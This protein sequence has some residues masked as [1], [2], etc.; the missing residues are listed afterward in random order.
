[1]KTR[2]QSLL[3]LLGTLLL[4][5]VGVPRGALGA[6]G[7][8]DAAY[9]PNPG[10]YVFCG[11]LQPDGKLVIGG[12]FGNIGATARSRIARLDANGVVDAAFNPGANNY[13]RSLVVQADGKIIVGGAFTT[14]AGGARNMIARLNA[15]GTLDTTFNPNITGAGT[16][17]D[18]VIAMATQPDGKIVVGGVFTAVG[19]VTRNYVARL[20][21]D[22]T[23]DAA[24][25]PNANS[26]VT[27]MSLRSDGKIFIGG[28]FTSVGASSG[29]SLAL[30]N[31]DGTVSSLYGVNSDVWSLAAQA[32]GKIVFG[33]SFSAVGSF[34]RH[35]LARL[36]ADGS[37]DTLFNPDVTLPNYTSTSVDD[38][39]IQTNGAMVI[40]GSFTTVG[41]VTHKSLARLNPD[42]T[43]DAVFNPILGNDI[44]G[45]ILQNDGRI[46][47]LSPV[48]SVGGVTRNWIARLLNDPT[49]ESLAATAVS[50]VQWLRGGASP[51]AAAVTFELSTDGGG[52]WTALGAGT[53]VTGGWE[54]TGL[55]LPA[56][57]TIRARAQTRCGS[58]N[59]SSGLVEKVA[60]FDVPPVLSPVTMASNNANPALAKTG[61]VITVS[62]TSN[63]AIQTPV[64]TLAGRA[65]TVANAGGNNWTGAITVAAGDSQGA[66]ALSIVFQDL[67]GTSGTTV[68][69]VTSG[70]A[71]SIDTVAPGTPSPP[72]LASASD[73]GASNTDNITKTTTP[74][75]IG[76]ATTGATVTLYDTNGTTVLG[77]ATATSGS[78]SIVSTTLG[79]GNHTITAKASDA[80]GNL[81]AASSGLT[82]TIDTAAPILSPV[83]VA[84]NNGVGGATR[85]RAGDSITLSFTSN[86]T[87]Q[88]PG[89]SIAGHPATVKWRRHKL[90]REHHGGCGRPAGTGCV[91]H[92]RHRSRWE[93]RGTQHDDGWQRRDRGHDCAGQTCRVGSC[94]NVGFR[95]LGH[96]SHHQVH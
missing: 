56:S 1:M 54:K 70:G 43:L 83:T 82:V 65:A 50:R 47:I 46:V 22:G 35:R 57:G 9:N 90:D 23:L 76:T 63:E 93:R 84:S 91:C 71:V 12:D 29:G 79:A 33:G 25:N 8:L 66:V 87:I 20:N 61:D 62:F 95:H 58:H 41:G 10:S 67:A 32:D 68:T 86:E 69:A 21:A 80:A 81:S 51:E 30:L 55:S 49:T 45:G 34:T 39:L 89:V 3:A 74:T 72:D 2:L 13:V 16:I 40:C 18:G 59:A 6:A 60:A 85:A 11:A 19:G 7:D 24:F 73:T 64:V 38:I 96:R 31:A 53:R 94:R 37:M 14:I 52:T 28:L 77:T 26:W 15:D 17:S 4:L 92:H 78:W 5:A 75:F 42:G 36:N 27:C 44:G 48:G 88:T